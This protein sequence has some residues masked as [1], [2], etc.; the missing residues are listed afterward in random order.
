MMNGFKSEHL[1]Y[2][3]EID[4]ILIYLDLTLEDHKLIRKSF[5][6]LRI[7][8]HAEFRDFKPYEKIIDLINMSL[9]ELENYVPLNENDSYY[10]STKNS[11]EKFKHFCPKNLYLKY[12][13]F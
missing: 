9:Q 11:L 13:A 2:I 5:R 3:N 6:N 1:E 7:S 4:E 12:E 10:D 8:F